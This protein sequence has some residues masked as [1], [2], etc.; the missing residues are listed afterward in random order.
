MSGFF[1]FTTQFL[2]GV[3]GYSALQAG[4]AFLPMTIVNFIV[5]LSIPQLTRRFGNAALLAAGIAL[6][7]A[8]M[9]WLSRLDGA[10]S[11]V[12]A[13]ALPMVLIGAGQGLAF[14]PLTAA[15]ITG[16]TANEA[17]AASGLVN[18]AHQLGSALGLGILVAFSASSGAGVGDPVAALAAHVSTALTGGSLL[19]AGC[20]ALAIMVIVPSERHSAASLGARAKGTVHDLLDR[21]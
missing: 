18:T 6:T 5:A 15:G 8:G 1:Y 21:S 11:Y 9:T 12:V 4:I 20:L 10:S 3:L 17:G 16:V 7:L 2:Q 19:L 13:V 14:A